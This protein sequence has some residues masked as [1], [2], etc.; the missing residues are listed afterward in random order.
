MLRYCL[1]MLKQLITYSA[2]FTFV[3]LLTFCQEEDV[4]LGQQSSFEITST[5]ADATYDIQVRLPLDYD[6]SETYDTIYILDSNWYFDHAS[7]EI[8]RIAE[9]SGKRAV[10]V[11][12]ISEG[13]PRTTDYM[14]TVTSQREKGAE[15][16]THFLVKELIPHM[17]ENFSAD[18][19]RASRGILGHSVGGLYVV[20]AFTRHN[21][22]FGNYLMLSPA[23]WYEDGAT[24]EYE[25]DNR[26]QNQASNQLVFISKA[27]L[28]ATQLFT[29]ILHKRLESYENA[30]VTLHTVNGKDHASS[31][32]PAITEGLPFYYS[33]KE[34]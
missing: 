27:E 30:K 7:E 3:T 15:N 28:E 10:I 16:F 12:G 25:Q 20:Y 23:I 33:L 11:V 2:I 34:N 32:K 14:P 26:S 31:A 4:E 8:A 17:E 21:Q 22:L 19:T 18:T 29:N 5:H 9:S 24:L 13:N 6:F 1:G